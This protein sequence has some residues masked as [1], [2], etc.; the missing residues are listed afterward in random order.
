VVHASLREG[1]ARVLVQGLLCGKPVVSYD[2]DGA[3]EVVLDGVTG[4]LVPAESV[5]EMA[6]AVADLIDHP[7]LA[8]RMGAEARRRFRDQFRAETMVRRLEDLYRRL[9]RSKHIMPAC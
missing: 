1:L 7:E 3:P 5:A 4:R 2:V 8:A 6:D 9:L